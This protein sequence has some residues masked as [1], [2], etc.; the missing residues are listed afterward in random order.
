MTFPLKAMATIFDK[1]GL[2]GP[3]AA[4]AV[5]YLGP[6][7]PAALS[8]SWSLYTG[9]PDIPVLGSL[10]GGRA[11]LN[12]AV[13]PVPPL[14][15]PV[16]RVPGDWPATAHNLQRIMQAKAN[17]PDALEEEK[18]GQQGNTEAGEGLCVGN[19]PRHGLMHLHEPSKCSVFRF[20]RTWRAGPGCT[21]RSRGLRAVSVVK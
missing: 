4:H 18:S 3:S 6:I 16:A 7:I 15:G 8:R 9:N 19:N 2:A 13:S 21:A 14:R 12:R 5:L 10:P 20:P 11:G 1:T 17:I